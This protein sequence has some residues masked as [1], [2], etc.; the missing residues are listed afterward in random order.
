MLSFK[1]MHGLGN[2]FVMIDARAAGLALSGADICAIA[3]RRLGVGCDQ[4]IVLEPPRTP[5]TDAFMRIY[6]PDGSEAGACGNGTRCA[7]AM[8]G[9]ESCVIE[10]ISGLLSCRR[11]ENDMIA[12]DMGAPRLDWADIPLSEERD[13]LHLGIGDGDTLS[14]PVAVNMGNPHC[15]F[16][17]QGV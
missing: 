6:N 1:K 17:V 4:V 12:V 15:V 10:T 7:A 3:D 16:F 8:I 9:G 5:G 2:D 11:V 13:T 14:D